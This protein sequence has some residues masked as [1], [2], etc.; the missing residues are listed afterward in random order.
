MREFYEPDWGQELCVGSRQGVVLPLGD[1]CE[2]R[3]HTM[4]SSS[5]NRFNC[6]LKKGI[7]AKG[8]LAP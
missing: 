5:S 7:I 8:L 4:T 1:G 2:F 6:I 3:L